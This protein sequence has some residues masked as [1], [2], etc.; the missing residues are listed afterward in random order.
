MEQSTKFFNQI[1]VPIIEADD[2]NDFEKLLFSE[3]YTMANSF[4]SVFPSNA[5]LASRY[6]KSKKT[7]SV[8]LKSLQEKEYINLKYEYEGKEVKRRYILPYLH[9][10]KEGIYTDVNTPIHKCKEG[11]YTDVKD[12]IS[13]NKSVNKSNNNISDLSDK[14]S[15]LET[16]FNN[17]WKIYPNK[18][19]KP[20][21]LLAYK[22]AVKSGTTDE[23]IKTGLEKYLAEIRV[24]NTQQN[25]IKHGSTWF[26][27]KG[28]EDDYDLMPIQNQTY[29]NN[30]VV[31]GAPNWS[32]PQT[33]KDREYMT[34]E[35]VEALINGLGNP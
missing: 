12:N 7:I 34:D 33:K 17:I 6:G 13:T 30:K 16:R 3:I 19:G 25:Y 5:F 10:C 32:N 26:N 27:G 14:E 11:I 28:W 22:R 24:K 4:G 1:P 35:E 15:D 21:A 8:T 23:E 20:K 2:L 29:N 18:K 9:K 31:K